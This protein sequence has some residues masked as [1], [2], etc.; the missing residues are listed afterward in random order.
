MDIVTKSL[1]FS[2]K[3]YC[4]CI[5]IRAKELVRS[6][7][8]IEDLCVKEKKATTKSSLTGY[9][10]ESST[11]GWYFEIGQGNGKISHI[12]NHL[13]I[14]QW[15]LGSGDFKFTRWSFC[16]AKDFLHL[17]I[18]HRVNLISTRFSLFDDLLLSSRFACNLT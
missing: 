11:V 2:V 14:N 17:S 15:I 5:G 6:Q 13:I 18:N 12:C 8:Q 16:L 10:N 4:V 1:I 9:W 7:S 3:S